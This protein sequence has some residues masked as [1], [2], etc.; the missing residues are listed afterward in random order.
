MM[1]RLTLGLQVFISS[2]SD[3]QAE[4]EEVTRAVLALAP[5]A[6][7]DDLLLTVYRFET[8]ALPTFERP[9][10]Q[11]N[12]DLQ[13][14]ELVIVILGK[15]VGSPSRPGSTETGT[16]E[17]IRIAEQLVQD[18][19]ADDLFLYY[20]A[21]GS[22][23]PVPSIASTMRPIIESRKQTV[24]PYA[25]PHCLGRLVAL[26][27]EKWLERWYDV[28]R[29][30]RH[31]FD[32]SELAMERAIPLGENR[33][34]GL[35]RTFELDRQRLVPKPICDVAIGMYQRHGPKAGELP[36]PREVAESAP[37]VVLPSDK[38]AQ[39][40]HIELFY[41]ACASG[42]IDAI[43]RRDP[44]A[45]ERKPYVNQVHQYLATLI[46]RR[47]DAATIA[48]ILRDW[49]RCRSGPD[50]VR[51][52]ARNFAAYVLGMIGDRSAADQLAES[53]V[54]DT[55]EGVRRYCI[56]SL[57]KLRA[58]RHMGLL[59]D[60]YKNTYDP[61]ERELIAKAICRIAGVA[62]FEL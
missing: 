47:P 38:G 32:R 18:G 35:L 36:L 9:L 61:Q 19:R 20:R 12:V 7:R 53:L 22:N 27:V 56:T 21:T 3:V 23:E 17:E 25:D 34:D 2:P 48:G 45:M 10:D 8:N 59:R 46:R 13:A 58:R 14:S 52:V 41:L 40:V 33:L 43:L 57:A 51:P 49:L 60:T 62:H 50:V 39:F 29:I 15:G 24:W 37:G 5:R 31:A 1:A 55:G 16:L 44:A 11:S 26:H 30:C 42:L 28:P 4:R 6:A 54:E